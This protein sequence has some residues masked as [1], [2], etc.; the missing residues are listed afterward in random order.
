MFWVNINTAAFCLCRHSLHLLL[1]K[2]SMGKQF[3]KTVTLTHRSHTMSNGDDL[4][5]TLKTILTRETVKRSKQFKTPSDGLH[6][7]HWKVALNFAFIKRS[8]LKMSLSTAIYAEHYEGLNDILTLSHHCI[9]LVFPMRMTSL[10]ATLAKGCEA[11]LLASRYWIR[12]I[13]KFFSFTLGIVDSLFT[14]WLYL[15]TWPTKGTHFCN[16]LRQGK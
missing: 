6:K 2:S 15:A 13:K 12:D 5:E 16:C 14:V 4:L 8:E 10:Q 7:M 9:L 11:L 1:Q 3:T